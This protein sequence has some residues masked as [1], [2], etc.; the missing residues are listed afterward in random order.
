[1]VFKKHRFL[2]NLIVS[3]ESRR[4][5]SSP[6]VPAVLHEARVLFWTD[7]GR[8]KSVSVWQLWTLLSM[9]CVL[10]YTTSV[11]PHAFTKTPLMSF[12]IN[13]LWSL[14]YGGIEICILLLLL[15]KLNEHFRQYSRETAE[16]KSLRIMCVLVKYTL[17]AAVWRGYQ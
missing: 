12:C 17:I 6:D 7:S 2:P 5:V 9:I 1:M 13:R 11:Q 10:S 16:S 14:T 4:A 8:L 3:N 15:T